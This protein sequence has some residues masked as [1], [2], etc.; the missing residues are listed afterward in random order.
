MHFQ[1]TAS[2]AAAQ[3]GA[4]WPIYRPRR[5][6]NNSSPESM[7]LRHGVRRVASATQ[8]AVQSS[9]LLDGR[10][11][12]IQPHDL[13]PKG[14]VDMLTGKPVQSFNDSLGVELPHVDLTD[15]FDYDDIEALK[16]ACDEAGGI[17][18]FTNQKPEM[19]VHDHVRFARSVADH[20]NTCLEPHGVAAGHK[21]A[22]EM[23]EIVREANAGVV[24]GENWH[25]D[26]SFHDESASYSILRGA[27]VPRLGVN[28]TLFSSVEDAWDALPQEKKDLLI[29]LRCFHSA[30]RAYGKGHGGNSRA[31][32]EKTDTMAFKKDMPILD[33]DVL[34]PL[35]SMHPR[36][37]RLG[38]FASPTF[39]THIEGVSAEENKEILNFVYQWF[40]R[41]EFCTRVSWQPNQVVMW[42]NRSLSHKGV[43]DECSERRVVQRVTVRGSSPM[44]HRGEQWS[45]TH[46]VKAAEA[47]LFE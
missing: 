2:L 13:R 35:V 17:V 5:C 15:D 6:A 45:L 18:V 4:A 19:T 38:L 26:F 37:G 34:Q 16:Q 9:R 23:L 30:N 36:T 44:N 24:F 10:R 29:D 47:G 33:F 39:T 43:A 27:E 31:A 7:L 8:L 14:V 42:D 12:L 20:D 25:S 3:P 11:P 32:M 40:A 41:P 46:K 1:M 22:P 21:D 28:D